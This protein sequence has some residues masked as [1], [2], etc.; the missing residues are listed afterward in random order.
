MHTALHFS[1]GKDSM[2]CLYLAR[3]QLHE[4]H[5]IFVNTGAL[6]PEVLETIE[7][8]KALCPHF[9]EVETDQRQQNIEHGLPSQIVP[10]NNT[11][12]GMAVTPP[13]WPKVQSYLQCC[14]A[15]IS[16]PLYDK[17]LELGCTH[18][19]RGQR[20]DDTHKGPVRHGQT[21]GGLTFLHPIEEWTRDMVL[22]Y[23]KGQMGE[24]PGHFALDHSS[25]DCYNCTAFLEHSADRVNYM[26]GRHP[27]KY[28][29]YMAR[30]AALHGAVQPQAAMLER[31]LRIHD[32]GMH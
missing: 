13:T 20:N 10:V 26:K 29:D 11:D 19:I 9:V 16:K 15:N 8:A 30:L 5:V 12:F 28:A 6:Y 22:D 1:G 23:L 27:E 3:E 18:V 32:G 31:L 2:A 4:I 21:V 7:K 14:W 25:M 17:T 24:L